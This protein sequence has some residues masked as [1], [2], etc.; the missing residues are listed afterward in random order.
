MER[1]IAPRRRHAI[2]LI[3]AVCLVAINMR[4]TI[5]AVGP[6]LEQI[7]SDT[8]LS[9]AVLGLLA[10]VPLATWA[11]VSPFAHD[12]SRRFGMSRVVLWALLLLTAGTAVRSLPGPTVS[13][14]AGT[15][16]IGVA[17]AIANVLM[18]ALIK[19]DFARVSVMMAVYTALLGGFGAI[20]SG[21]AVPISLIQ[22]GG[23]PAGWRAALL[24]T[25]GILLPGAI[26][27]CAWALRG[28]GP[29]HTPQRH[30]RTGIWADRV[31]WIVAAYMGLQSASFYMQVTW[32]AAI[33]IDTGRTEVAAG[34]DVMIYQVGA[35]VGALLLPFA[36]RGRSE[37]LAPAL[38]PVLGL[39]GIGGLMLAPTGITAWVVLSGLA[40]GAS[41]GM[42]LTLMALRA[43]DHE[44]SSALSGMAQSI[45]Y[46]VAALGPVA[47][48]A[49]HSATGGWIASLALLL[50]VLVGQLVVGVYAG[51]DRFVLDPR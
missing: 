11:I 50:A 19:R 48:G 1:A 33:S 47:F 7:G 22:I 6:L 35:V 24:I 3:A 41:L 49:L 32:L 31:A 34:I 36:L 46:I 13:L 29:R 23:E 17:L 45:G 5:T 10:S 26:I 14:W 40:S 28:R 8:G 43:R 27:F 25:G 30:R 42:S 37:R 15:A 18:P 44:A 4:P 12:L 2:A 21:V 39:I 20:A 38:V 9:V 51:R 16:L